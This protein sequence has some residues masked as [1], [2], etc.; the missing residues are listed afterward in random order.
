VS[1]ADLRRV[2]ALTGELGELAAAPHEAHS[3]L[4]ARI[5]ALVGESAI[6]SNVSTGKNQE[7]VAWA[8]RGVDEEVVRRWQAEWVA[9]HSYRDHPMWPAL[10]G[11]GTAQT[12]RREQ[13]VSD[14]DWAMN[15]QIAEWG[16]ALGLDDTLATVAPIV[17]DA[18]ATLVIV[19]PMGERR[20]SARDA[21]LVALL[22]ANTAWLNRAAYAATK[23]PLERIRA[24]L[25]PRYARV[26]DELLAGRSEKQI[27]TRLALTVRTVHKYV[28]HV[29]RAFAVS[30][31]VELMA[32]F[33]RRSR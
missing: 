5:P 33:I 12:L 2:L 15:P 16:H 14:R 18:S 22:H 23:S 10:Y 31:G 4:L 24:S 29:Y 19:R 7:V 1:S 21:D 3:H 25:R 28:E 17:P 26:L 30:S 20:Y 11:P 6:W 32:L 9:A 27:A 8:V 13:I